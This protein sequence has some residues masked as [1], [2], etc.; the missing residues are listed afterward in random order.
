MEKKAL[1][2]KA[3][4]G[5]ISPD[6]KELEKFTLACL[7]TLIVFGVVASFVDVAWF[8]EVYTVEDGF[9][10]WLTVLPL[11]AVFF[12]CVFRITLR[13]RTASVQFL[14]GT[15]LIALLAILAIGEEI[16]WGQRIFEIESSSFFKENNAQQETNLHN[17]VVQGVKLNKI[18]FSQLLAGAAA[19]YLLALPWLYSK[20]ESIKALADGWAV[21]VP[22]LYQIIA[23]LSLF[24]LV[25]ICP[26]GKRAELMEMAAT[27]LFSLILFY[28]ANPREI[29]H[30]IQKHQP[31]L[32]IWFTPWSLCQQKQ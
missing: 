5:Y 13:W 30:F 25:S 27:T 28:P 7:F 17:M 22:R 10:E 4:T 23:F 19:L 8:E 9:I 2:E 20:N 11:V 24:A 16:S 31:K 32:A 18:I 12:F 3:P 14:L 6:L 29:P 15:S 1:T 26:S 21:P